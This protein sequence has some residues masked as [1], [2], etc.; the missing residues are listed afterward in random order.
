M[1][2]L[3]KWHQAV[4][5]RDLNILDDILDD[6]VVFH[7]PVLWT[8]QKG[9]DITKLY[10]GAA[11]NVLATADFK[12][13]NEIVSNNQV[14]LEFTTLIGET[15]VNGVDIITFNEQGKITEFKVMVRPIK[16][17]MAVKDKMLEFIQKMSS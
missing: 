17:M 15:V 1:E 7:S 11:M 16:G 5:K 13:V 2:H 4:G 9:K 8:P 12:Y 10:L 3:H 14:C 6:E